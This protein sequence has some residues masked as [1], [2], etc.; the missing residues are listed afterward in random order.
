MNTLK[1]IQTLSKI[2]KIVSKIIFI[3]CIVGFCGCLVGMISLAVGAPA[4]KL[5]GVTLES[6]LQNEAG[7]TTG[8]LYAELAAA[9]ILCAGEGVLAKFASRY[10]ERELSDGTPFTSG[11]AKELLRL[12]ILSICVPIGVRI[13]EQIVYAILKQ[14]MTDVAP[15]DFDPA[16]SVAI[17]VTMLIAALLCRYGAELTAETEEA[18]QN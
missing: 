17:G 18:R 9:M 11:G 13:A 12:G 7:K 14:V 2:G 6:V 5:G 1:T 10:F 4:L 16:G 3:C 15:Q 8:T